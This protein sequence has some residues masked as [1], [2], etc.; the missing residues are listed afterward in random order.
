[1][2]CKDINMKKN[3]LSK[4]NKKYRIFHKSE[5]IFFEWL[6]ENIDRF[7]N[8]PF[9]DGRGGFYFTG[10]IK[11]ISLH[12]DF[13][14]PE[15]MLSLDDIDSGENYD[16]ISIQY[17]GNEKYNSSKGFYDADRIDNIYTYYD[18]YKELIIIEVFEP[19]I[20]YCNEKFKEENSLYLIDY[21]GGTEAFI[22]SNDETDILKIKN[23]SKYIKRKLYINA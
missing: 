14:Q 13:N 1:M 23:K 21:N 5:S 8:K 2:I 7:N 4:I 6:H 22:A 15:A 11:S 16:F 18:S 12:I 17:I 10:I 3:K 20:K 9:P 19:I